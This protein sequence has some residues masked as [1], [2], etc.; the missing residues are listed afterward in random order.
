MQAQ[1]PRYDI[2]AFI[3]K[4][5][6]AY[7]SHILVT[8]GRTD[9]NDPEDRATGI[10]EVRELLA[11]CRSHVEHEDHFIHPAIEARRPGGTDWTAHD[12]GEHMAEFDALMRDTVEVEYCDGPART[13]AVARLYH[14]LAAFVAD[15]FSHMAREET[16]NNAAL[17]AAY[18]DEE[19][20][21]LHDQLVSSIP[22]EGQ[23]LTMR[24][25]VPHLTPTERALVLGGVKQGAPAEAF[26]G[27]MNMV[28]PLLPGKDW[29]KLTAALGV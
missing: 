2:Y 5:L 21:A 7:M 4:A 3:H 11:F 13:A 24:W 18:T 27:L 10:S 28:R 14:H 25:M 26:A 19:L 9:W 23:V 17:W 22:M 16:E 6:R 12:H 29:T 1:T 15:N 20:H 8:V